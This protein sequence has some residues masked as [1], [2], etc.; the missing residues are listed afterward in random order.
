MYIHGTVTFFKPWEIFF[1]QCGTCQLF[2]WIYFRTGPTI[3]IILPGPLLKTLLRNVDKAKESLFCSKWIRILFSIINVKVY[4]SCTPCP[5]L[6]TLSRSVNKAKQF[7]L[8]TVIIWSRTLFSMINV[9][10]YLSCTA[11]THFF[12]CSLI[13]WVF[14]LIM[15]GLHRGMIYMQVAWFTFISIDKNYFI[16]GHII[17]Q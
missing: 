13:W 5:L 16:T 1:I 11:C 14:V 8:F 9:N 4:Q 12:Q 6:K 7:L 17:W 3:V 2:Y 10:V 15:Y